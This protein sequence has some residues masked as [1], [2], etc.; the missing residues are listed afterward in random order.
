MHEVQAV[1]E[2][3]AR[4]MERATAP[5]RPAEDAHLLD[6][7]ELGPEEVLGRALQLVRTSVPQLRVAAGVA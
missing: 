7:S 4:D 1:R 6:S 3:D 2:R 5:L